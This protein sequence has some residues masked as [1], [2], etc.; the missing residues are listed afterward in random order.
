MT[1][2]Y[3]ISFKNS[4]NPIEHKALAVDEKGQKYYLTLKNN[5][6]VKGV[7]TDYLVYKNSES[8]KNFKSPMALPDINSE[9]K[10]SSTDTI[11]SITPVVQ[12]FKQTPTPTAT[13]V[14]EELKQ[15]Q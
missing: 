13:T 1:G 15:I 8:D 2:G 14:M 12:N 5:D 9:I 3:T 7:S 6:M 10:V 4:K 11:N